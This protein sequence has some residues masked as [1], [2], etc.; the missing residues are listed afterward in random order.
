MSTISLVIAAAALAGPL[1]PPAGPIAPTP[2]PEPRIAINAV[3]TPGSAT[4]SFII[5][6]PGS[7]YLE[8]N[9]LGEAGKTGILVNADEVSID[10]MGFSLEGVPGSLDGIGS[11][12][13]NVFNLTLRNGVIKTWGEDGVDLHTVGMLADQVRSFDNA[14]YGFRVFG[15]D[16]RDC[17]AFN[18]NQAGIEFYEGSAVGC[19]AIRNNGTGIKANLTCI[20]R[21]CVA[22]YNGGNGIDAAAAIVR[23]CMAIGNSSHGISVNGGCTVTGNTCSGNG[24]L[25]TTGAGI[26]VNSSDNRIE[27]NNCVGNDYGV[28]VNGEGNFIIKNTCSANTTNWIFVANN[29]YSNIVNRAGATTNSVNGDSAVSTLGTVDHTANF[30]Y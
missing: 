3:N 17:Q 19:T 13:L 30:T 23:N 27:D 2:G 4:A 20:V 15:A 16:L 9:I 11:T 22:S 5:S 26:L 24:A 8:G 1:D 29:F 28:R 21:D 14:L 25:A 6:A 12:Q 18:N 7:Y 10:L